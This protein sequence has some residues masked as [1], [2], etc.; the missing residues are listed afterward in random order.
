M[1]K[2]NKTLYIMDLAIPRDVDCEVGKL[3]MVNLYNVDDLKKISSENERKR[4]EL[5]LKAKVMIDTDVEDFIKWKKNIKVDYIIK[6][7][8]NKNKIIKEDILNCIYRKLEL[9]NR[10]KKVIDKMVNS[11]LKRTIRDPII[12]LKEIEDEEK[13]KNYT[14]MLNELMDFE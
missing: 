6:A 14:N 7:I 3:N 2:L 4:E 8:N 5:S 11:G 1:P 12:K 9:D 10:E 13:I